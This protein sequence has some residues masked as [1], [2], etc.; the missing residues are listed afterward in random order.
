MVSIEKSLIYATIYSPT[1]PLYYW[2]RG[3]YPLGEVQDLWRLM[4]KVKVDPDQFK[5][6][7]R[8]FLRTQQDPIEERES[9]TFQD[10]LGRTFE[11]YIDVIVVKDSLFD[12]TRAYESTSI[13]YSEDLEIVVAFHS[14]ELLFEFIYKCNNSF[15]SF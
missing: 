14:E 1:N 6:D 2:G 12:I 3:L 5:E 4:P 7:F 13:K 15:P 10:S 8:A 9:Y 11:A